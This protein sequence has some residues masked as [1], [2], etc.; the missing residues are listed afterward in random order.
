MRAIAVQ[1]IFSLNATFLSGDLMAGKNLA[2]GLKS[3]MNLTIQFHLAGALLGRT[4]SPP[5]F[6]SFSSA[7]SE[8]RSIFTRIALEIEPEPR[9]LLTQT[10]PKSTE[11]F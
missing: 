10:S 7:L 1:N 6:F 8:Q 4:A 5:A 3:S 9:R 11:T 2:S